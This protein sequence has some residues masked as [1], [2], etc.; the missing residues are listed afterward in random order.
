[1]L[2]FRSQYGFR[3]HWECIG[4]ECSEVVK[5]REEVAE[6][7]LAWLVAAFLS[8]RDCLKQTGHMHSQSLIEVELETFLS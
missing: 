2:F 5:P 6:Y 7:A 4:D 1:M 8:C 3:C